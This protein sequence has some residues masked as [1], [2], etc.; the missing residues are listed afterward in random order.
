ML[1]PTNDPMMDE[2]TV[3]SELYTNL[4]LES[5]SPSLGGSQLPVVYT[6]K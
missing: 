5:E 3:Q 4:G 2:Q 6:R 1:Q